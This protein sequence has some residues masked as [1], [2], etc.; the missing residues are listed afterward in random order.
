[1]ERIKL[2]KQERHVLKALERYGDECKVDYP[3]YE[4][5]RTIR[6]LQRKRLV[7]GA[8]IEGGG[9]E[10]VR[11]TNEGKSYLR[12][13]PQLKNP[14]DWKWIITTSVALASAVFAAAALFVA[15]SMRIG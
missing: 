8:Y 14:I 3:E 1:M 13:N 5:S 9:V 12:N 7:K 10:A 6:S 4:F 11:I 15:F 2:T